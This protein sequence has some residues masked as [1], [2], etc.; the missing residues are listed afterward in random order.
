[1][2]Q[3]AYEREGACATAR[4]RAHSRQRTL[5]PTGGQARRRASQAAETLEERF[6]AVIEA[7]LAV[8]RMVVVLL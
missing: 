6:E 7:S 4:L 1:M 2:S 3:A 8:E 5:A